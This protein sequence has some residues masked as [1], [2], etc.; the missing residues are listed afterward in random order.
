MKQNHL[1]NA[2]VNQRWCASLTPG[3][4]DKEVPHRYISSFYQ[5]YFESYK[6]K[7][8]LEIGVRNGYSI[9]LWLSSECVQRVVGIDTDPLVVRENTAIADFR[10]TFHLADA[11]RNR[12]RKTLVG[13]QKFD[14][15]IDDGPHSL[16]T[17][18]FAV[19]YFVKYLAKSGTLVVED[20]Q[21]PEQSANLILNSLPFWFRGKVFMLDLRT[22]SQKS[23]SFLIVIQ[24]QKAAHKLEGLINHNYQS[25]I[26][27]R[28][29]TTTFRSHMI[30]NLWKLKRAGQYFL[31]FLSTK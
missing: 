9:R 21:D 6:P 30:I 20:I 19:R 24:K 2:L 31:N 17:Q 18:M 3:G 5:E 26:G 10:Y 23:D 22:L 16:I 28:D 4:S 25:Q 14:L 11:Y 29:I 12:G 7:S 1:I 8:I 15:I 27:I 13:N